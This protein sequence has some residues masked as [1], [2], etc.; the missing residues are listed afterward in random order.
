MGQGEPATRMGPRPLPLHLASAVMIAT[1][2]LAALPLARNGSIAWSASLRD[3]ARALRPNLA[4]ANPDRLARALIAEAAVRQDAM[5]RG[6][7]RYRGHPYRRDLADPPTVWRD[8]AARLLDYGGDG[9]AVLCVCSLI[10]RA[11]VIDLSRRR[12]LLRYL[13][14]LG[15]RPLLLDWGQAEA[16]LDLDAVMTRRLEPA[17]DAAVTLNGGPVMVLGYCMGGTL[18]VALAARHPASVG[19]LALLGAPWDF[20][21]ADPTGV[22]RALSRLGPIGEAPIPLDV[23]QG[24]F[25]LLD[26]GLAQRKFAG[27]A[28]IPDEDEAADFVAVEDWLNDGVALPAGVARDCLRDWYGANATRNGT[29]RLA[30]QTVDPRRIAMPSL[31][32]VPGTDRIVPPACAGALAEAL[33]NA[34]RLDVEAGHIGMVVGPRAEAMLWRPLGDWLLSR[35]TGAARRRRPAAPARRRTARSRQAAEGAAV[36]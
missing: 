24:Y 3:A 23:L 27:F 6:I 17:L 2:S 9:P 14:A 4:S 12:S 36:D 35:A 16:D 28:A 30:G 8:G 1:S 20:D 25:A 22:V 21:E 31:V 13:A 19:A 34:T 7:A 18:S 11:Y 10:N 15:L 33:P 32:V 26:P 5:L 29:W